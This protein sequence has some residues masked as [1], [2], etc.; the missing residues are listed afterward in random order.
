[1]SGKAQKTD[2]AAKTGRRKSEWTKYDDKLAIWLAKNLETVTKLAKKRWP[3]DDRLTPRMKLADQLDMPPSSISRICK[4][5]RRIAAAELPVI[6][7]FFGRKAP[8]FNIKTDR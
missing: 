4:K 2:G 5:R 6:E 3:G 7:L 1:M 8:R